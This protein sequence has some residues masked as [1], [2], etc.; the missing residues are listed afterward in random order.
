MRRAGIGSD[1]TRAADRR[2][3]RMAILATIANTTKAFPLRSHSASVALTRGSIEHSWSARALLSSRDPGP[4][5]DSPRDSREHRSAARRPGPA[6]ARADAPKARERAAPGFVVFPSP[7]PAAR[8]LPASRITSATMP[9]PPLRVRP[10]PRPAVE[11]ASSLIAHARCVKP[12]RHSI[13]EACVRWRSR[14]S[15]RTA[16]RCARTAPNGARQTGRSRA[17]AHLRGDAFSDEEKARNFA[18]T[19]G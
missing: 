13:P 16:R 12:E 10:R 9:Q 7:S 3:A 17:C 8:A 5:A 4:R 11:A 1:Q 18:T 14:S 15:A 6:A 19:S 2:S